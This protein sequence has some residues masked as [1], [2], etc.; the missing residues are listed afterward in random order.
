MI[1]AAYTARPTHAH[2]HSRLHRH[3]RVRALGAAADGR[4]LDPRRHPRPPRAHVTRRQRH[5]Q[6]ADVRLAE[7]RQRQNHRL[8]G[9]PPSAT[10]TS[11]QRP[12]HGARRA[13]CSRPPK[14]TL[15]ARTSCT[16]RYFK[17]AVV[18]VKAQPARR[19]R[20]ATTAVPAALPPELHGLRFHDLRHTAA[21]LFI[22]TGGQ[23][24]QVMERMGHADINT[25]YSAT[26]TYSTV[27]TPQCWKL[28][29]PPT[30]QLAT[31]FRCAARMV[32]RHDPPA[33]RHPARAGRCRRVRQLQSLGRAARVGGAAR[34]RRVHV[35]HGGSA[36][37]PRD[38]LPGHRSPVRIPARR[39]G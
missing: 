7:E 39:L 19:G 17:P 9:V 6:R 2:L 23:P 34:V 12:P 35:G 21:S 33:A 32:R 25:T 29:T 26:V 38:G 18:G 31:S 37:Q 36:C 28:W 14:A 15:C 5:P 13:S 24:K 3:A 1:S 22:A 8:A 11:P 20:K 4:G 27:T 30:T 10:R 16:G